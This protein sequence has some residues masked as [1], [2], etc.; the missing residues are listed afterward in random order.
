MNV[1]GYRRGSI[2]WALT[3]IAVGA[4][5]LYHNF[6]PAIRPWHIIAKYW[7]ILIIFW[8][9]S[10][11]IDYLQASQ[12]P[13]TTPPPLFTA[14]EVILLF[15]VLV[16]G[17]LVSRVVLRPAHEWPAALGIDLDTDFL[18]NTYSYTQTLSQPA[19]AE[20]RLIVEDQ[21]GDLEIHGMDRPVI[22]AV[23]KREIKAENEEAAKKLND[24]LKVEIVEQA[25]SYVLRSN[26]PSLPGGGRVARLD[27]VLHVPKA[28]SADVISERGEVIIDGLKGNQTVSAQRGD[29]RI[30]SVEGLVRIHKSGG[31]TTVRDVKGNVDIDGRGRDVEATAVTGSVTV[32]GEFSGS[33]QFSNVAQTL[34]FNSS[35]TEL[36]A[37]KLSGRLNM[38]LGS[39]DARGLDGPFEIA[40]RQKDIT[41][42]EFKHSVKIKTSNGTVRLETSVVP[43]QPVE[44]DL[45]KGDIELEL[46][47]QSNFQIDASAVH[48]EVES[49]FSGPG[50]NINKRAET[51][52]ITGSYGRGG[53]NI[54]LTTSYGTI[55]LQQGGAP[56]SPASEAAPKKAPRGVPHPEQPATPAPA[57]A[58]A[59]S[60]EK[61]ARALPDQPVGRAEILTDNTAI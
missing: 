57:A 16:T 23:I 49:D 41:L 38:E 31:S 5:F 3:L 39:L 17:S 29:V 15:L 21:R 53:A 34:R 27:I 20:I 1:Y 14:S 13:E 18:L 24:E 52:S 37:Q 26:R 60:S 59:S 19:R 10:K 43:T 8:G 58:P 4:L 36:T 30:A 25:G 7:P 47:P 28:T 54:R 32:N 33:V 44:V 9:L 11:L 2:F 48:G 50:L 45:K 42:E 35:R 56:P 6:N 51:P 61:T 55:H 40:T 12:H 22:E 46:P